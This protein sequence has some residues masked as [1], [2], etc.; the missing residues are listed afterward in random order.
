[1]YVNRPEKIEELKT[2]IRT[3]IGRE[4]EVEIVLSDREGRRSLAEIPVEERLKEEIQMP[5]E[6]EEELEQDI[7]S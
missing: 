7:F 3:V 6:V 2:A 4:A 1:M 5:V